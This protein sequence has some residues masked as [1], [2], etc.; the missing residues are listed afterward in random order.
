MRVNTIFRLNAIADCDIIRDGFIYGLRKKQMFK[1][2]SNGL[3]PASC[4]NNSSFRYRSPDINLNML[5]REKRRIGLGLGLAEGG[6][7]FVLRQKGCITGYLGIFEFERLHA[8]NAVSQHSYMF[9]SYWFI[10]LYKCIYLYIWLSIFYIYVV[11]Y[12]LYAFFIWT[13]LNLFN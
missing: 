8:R 2:R 6:C 12:L 10:Y 5:R 9:S 4:G 13:D 1:R 11:N 3:L 7:P